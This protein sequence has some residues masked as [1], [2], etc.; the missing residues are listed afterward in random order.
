MHIF[1]VFTQN[2]G[3]AERHDALIALVLVWALFLLK[4][5]QELGSPM[6]VQPTECAVQSQAPEVC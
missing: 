2:N 3:C 6:A 5:S 4:V 1:H